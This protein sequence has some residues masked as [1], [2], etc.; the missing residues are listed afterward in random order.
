MVIQEHSA[1]EV[2]ALQLWVKA[3]VRD[4]AESDAWYLAFFELA[5]FGWNYPERYTR[6]LEAVSVF[7]V[8]RVARRYLANPTT[9]ALRPPS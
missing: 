9:V 5:G 7:G 8:T 4:E 1:S 2:V 3:G 6:A